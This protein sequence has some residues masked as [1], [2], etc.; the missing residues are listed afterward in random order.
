[1]HQIRF[2]PGELRRYPRPP[3]RLGRGIPPPHSSP[4]DAFGI[5]VSAPLASKSVY[6]RLCFF[7]NS[8][9]CLRLN[10]FSVLSVSGGSLSFSLLLTEVQ[11]VNIV[12]VVC[13]GCR[14]SGHAAYPCHRLR[15]LSHLQRPNSCHLRHF[16]LCFNILCRWAW[17]AVCMGS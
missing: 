14:F 17:P 6:P 1:M 9:H 2:R 3:S 4:L 11:T 7:S 10:V 12:V 5:S 15:P 16:L 8:T 13:F